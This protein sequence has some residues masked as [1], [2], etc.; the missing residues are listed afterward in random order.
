MYLSTP[1]DFGKSLDVKDTR[2]ATLEIFFATKYLEITYREASDIWFETNRR[3]PL[4][5]E[6]KFSKISEDS[7]P[8]RFTSKTFENF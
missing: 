6:L 4:Q 1:F 3:R 8:I 5:L 7:P 2:L